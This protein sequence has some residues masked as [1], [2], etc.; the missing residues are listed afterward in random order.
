M[1][2]VEKMRNRLK[3]LVK[4]LRRYHLYNS[5]QRKNIGQIN[6]GP[7]FHRTKFLSLLRKDFSSF[8][9][10]LFLSDKVIGT[11]FICSIQIAYERAATMGFHDA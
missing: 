2:Y 4:I 6:V 8:L 5:Y 3:I 9:S 10:D 1:I 7:N 11:F